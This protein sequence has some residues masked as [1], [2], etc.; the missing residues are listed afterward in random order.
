MTNFVKITTQLSKLLHQ[1]N[2]EDNIELRYSISD[3]SLYLYNVETN[4]VMEKVKAPM[5]M[6]VVE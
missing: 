1:L 2:Q 6:Y 5:N 3:D 4:Q